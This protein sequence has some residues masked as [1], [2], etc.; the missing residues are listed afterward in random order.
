MTLEG[1][2]PMTPQFRLDGA[3]A[4]VTGGGGLIGEASTMALASAGARVVV[5]DVDGP[6]A[7]RAA[8]RVNL[9]FDGMCESVQCDIRDE[10]MVRRLAA[11]VESRF[12]PVTVLHNNA[13]TKGADFSAFFAPADEYSLATWNEVMAVNLSG[14]FLVTQAF[15]SSMVRNGVGSIIHTASIYGATMGPDQRIYGS[16]VLGGVPINTPPVYTASKAGVVGLTTHFAALWGQRG[17]RVN[18]LSPGGIR[19]SHNDTFA[20]AYSSRVPMNRMGRVED[21]MGPI[22]FLASS[23]SAY[24]TGQNLFVDGGLSSW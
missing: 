4:V 1:S 10:D 12:G 14:M 16:E 9:A 22:V 18:T 15:G 21:L 20:A 7:D 2:R 8:T 24:I 5:V 6:A 13:A 23:A 17:I 3:V 11:H 19:T